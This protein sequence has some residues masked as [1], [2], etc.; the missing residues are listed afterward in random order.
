[1][2]K[3]SDPTVP[4]HQSPAAGTNSTVEVY[5]VANEPVPSSA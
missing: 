2:T 1:M 4:I 3:Q 5:A